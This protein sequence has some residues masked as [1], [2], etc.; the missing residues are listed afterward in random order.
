MRTAFVSYQMVSGMQTGKN[1]CERSS[2]GKRS[3]R[4]SYSLLS[5]VNSMSELTGNLCLMLLS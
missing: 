1:L 4:E 3:P 2:T 5:D